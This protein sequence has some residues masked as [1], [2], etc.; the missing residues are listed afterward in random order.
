MPKCGAVGNTA[1][2][3]DL[4]YLEAAVKELIDG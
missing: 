3:A 4:S 2:N 1:M